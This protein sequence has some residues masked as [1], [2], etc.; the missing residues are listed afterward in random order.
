MNPLF[1]FYF[2]EEV[3]GLEEDFILSYFASTSS[4]PM[5][6]PK[7]MALSFFQ[8]ASRH[9]GFCAGRPGRMFSRLNARQALLSLY[10]NWATQ[11]LSLA[12]LVHF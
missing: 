10:L 9:L 6:A 5:S 8:L 3:S 2:C 4:F 7:W 1:L 11:G 12:H